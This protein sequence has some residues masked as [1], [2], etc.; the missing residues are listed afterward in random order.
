MNIY[1]KK[2][3]ITTVEFID[4]KSQQQKIRNPLIERISKILDDGQY[5]L[6]SEVLDLEN[7]LSKFSGSKHTITCANGTDALM[8]AMLALGIGPG[9]KVITVPFTYIATLEA[10]AAI[11]ATPVLIDVYDET[12]NMNPESIEEIIKNLKIKSKQ[13]CPLIFLAFQPDTD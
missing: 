8:L 13:S 9:D 2:L 7:E 5:I 3:Y 11:G 1:N 12:F 4:L 6:G 10:I